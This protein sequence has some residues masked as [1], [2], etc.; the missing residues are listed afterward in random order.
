MSEDRTRKKVIEVEKFLEELEPVIPESL[1]EYK[2]D[3]KTKAICERYFEKIVEAVVDIA[4]FVIKNKRL[5]QPDY[6]KQVFNILAENS[7]IS[8]KFSRRLQEAKG[9]KNI[10]THE[11][12]RIDDA[13]VFHSV[14]EELIPN[15]QEFIKCINE[16][17]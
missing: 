3:Y 8:L 12:G 13:Q 9:M 10:I 15:V 5:K 6:E 11:Y 7:I 16:V 2:Q 1:E 17:K 4:F 14:S